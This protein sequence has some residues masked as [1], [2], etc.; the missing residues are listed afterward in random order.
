MSIENP[1]LAHFRHFSSLF[2]KL[3]STSVE[4]SL[5]IR[6]FYAKQTQSQVGQ[7]QRKLFYD[8]Q[9]RV[10]GHLVIQTNKA[11]SNPIQSQFK[12]KQTQNKPNVESAFMAKPLQAQSAKMAQKLTSSNHQNNTR[13]NYNFLQTNMLNILSRHCPPTGTSFAYLS[14]RR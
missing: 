14:L 2:I 6:P 9:I 11:N 7:N 8:M 3:P 4:N 13:E 12:P 5:Q 10:M 1:T